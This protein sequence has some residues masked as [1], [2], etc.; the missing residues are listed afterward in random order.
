MLSMTESD[1]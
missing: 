1:F